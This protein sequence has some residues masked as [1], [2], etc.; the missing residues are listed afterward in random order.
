MKKAM[1]FAAGLGTRLKPLTDHTPKALIKIKGKPMLQ[2]VIEQLKQ[3]GI[4]EIIINVHYLAEQIIDFIK[5]N[6]QFDIRIEISDERNLLLDTGGGLL[7]AQPFFRESKEPFLVCNADIFTNINIGNFLEKH[8]QNKSLATLAVRNRNASR[9]LLF[10]DDEILFGWENVS[11]QTFKIP[12][13]SPQK[14][15]TDENGTEKLQEHPLHEFAFSGYHIIEP[16]IFNLPAPTD[17]FSMTDWYLDLCRRHTI[18]SYTHNDDI[19]IDIGTEE[20]L[21][22]CENFVHH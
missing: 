14:Y 9:Y 16:E 19:W 10:D 13:K 12:R 1:I 20:K 11:T 21:R 7:K 2:I 15:F 3:Q 8:Q 18:K 4:T 5:I 22:A 17:V 6:K